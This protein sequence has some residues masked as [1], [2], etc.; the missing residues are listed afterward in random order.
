MLAIQKAGSAML[1][2]RLAFLES[3]QEI[4]DDRVQKPSESTAL[5]PHELCLSK[6]SAEWMGHGGNPQWYGVKGPE[7]AA[8]HLPSAVL[9]GRS[10]IA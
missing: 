9:K 4:N 5:H 3:F 10:M 8:L 1:H 7:S 6:K 2:W